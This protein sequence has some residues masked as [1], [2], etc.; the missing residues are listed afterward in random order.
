M[1]FWR[2]VRAGSGRTLSQNAFTERAMGRTGPGLLVQGPEAK[3]AAAQP[4]VREGSGPG[5]CPRS[6]PAS[7][8]DPARCPRTFL[9][10]GCREVLP[11]KVGRAH[12]LTVQRRN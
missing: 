7:A 4:G 9:G 8:R 2:G 5:L 6:T 3:E 1:E 11:L 12:P 10:A